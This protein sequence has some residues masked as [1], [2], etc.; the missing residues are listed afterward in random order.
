MEIEFQLTP[1]AEAPAEFVFY[2][3]KWNALCVAEEV[4]A[5]MHNLYAPRGAKTRDAL[6]WSRHLTDMLELF[7]DRMDVVLV[8]TIGRVGAV[9]PVMTISQSSVTCIASCT[10]KPCG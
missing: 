1:G 3:P 7:G 8:R 9:M 5:V 4:N 6:I 2:L 10:T